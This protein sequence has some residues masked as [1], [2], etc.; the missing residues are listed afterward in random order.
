M[1]AKLLTAV[2]VAS[3]AATPVLASPA[4]SLSLSKARAATKGKKSNELAPAAIIGVLATAALIGGAV[5]LANS[6]DTPD[7][8]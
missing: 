4:S 1:L 7:S 2:A 8:P 3:L 5:V 6:D